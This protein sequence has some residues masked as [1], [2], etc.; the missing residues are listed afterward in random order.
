MSEDGVHVVFGAGQVGRALAAH[1]IGMGLPV[2]IVSRARP[3]EPLV[4]VEWRPA[5]ASDPAAASDAAQGA[6]V[7]Y[8]CLNAPYAD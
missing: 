4:G 3:L 7:V 6:A 1:L 2:R 5:D 8:Q